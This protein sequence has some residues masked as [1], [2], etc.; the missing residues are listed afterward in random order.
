MVYDCIRC[1][2]TFEGESR[3]KTGLCSLCFYSIAK[4]E[5]CNYIQKCNN[6]FSKCILIKR[7]LNKLKSV[8]TI[9]DFIKKE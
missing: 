6:K 1:N 5:S 4:C 3:F 8:K 7:E 2:L 9:T